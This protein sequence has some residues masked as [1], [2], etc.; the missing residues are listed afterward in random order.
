[1]KDVRNMMTSP[2]AARPPS[3]AATTSDRKAQR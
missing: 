1:M 2:R 3:P